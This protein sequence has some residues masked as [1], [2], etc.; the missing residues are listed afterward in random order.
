MSSS[1]KLGPDVFTVNKKRASNNSGGQ[2]YYAWMKKV[3]I[4]EEVQGG[5]GSEDNYT[6]KLHVCEERKKTVNGSIVIAE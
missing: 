3:L 6:S 4:L 5:R 1:K 2:S